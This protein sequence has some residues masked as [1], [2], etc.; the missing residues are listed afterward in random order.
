MEEI[1]NSLPV[2]FTVKH[3]V[4]IFARIYMISQEQEQ[5]GIELAF[6][7]KLTTELPDAIQP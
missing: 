3:K 1:A 4:T 6:Q 7:S 2:L 5:A